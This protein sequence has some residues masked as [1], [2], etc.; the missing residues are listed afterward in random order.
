[1]TALRHVLAQRPDGHASRIPTVEFV[2]V[3]SAAERLGLKCRMTVSPALVHEIDI[4]ATVQ[5]FRDLLIEEPRDPSMNLLR[6][7]ALMGTHAT[8]H[9]IHVVERVSDGFQEN[10]DHWRMLA[11]AAMRRAATGNTEPAELAGP[12][13]TDERVAVFSPWPVPAVPGATSPPLIIVSPLEDI[14]PDPASI[15]RMEVLERSRIERGSR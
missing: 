8:V 1:M 2:D 5:R 3:S 12:A 7:M 6:G 14:Y 10:R 13:G 15:L 4:D 9:R 11:V